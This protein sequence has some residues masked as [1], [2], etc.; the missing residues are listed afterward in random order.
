MPQWDE[1]IDDDE[2]SQVV[3]A[4]TEEPGFQPE[5]DKDDGVVISEPPIVSIGRARRKQYLRSLQDTTGG[6]KPSGTGEIL[7]EDL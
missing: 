7:P 1:L 4:D 3:E 2:N 6:D 5:Y